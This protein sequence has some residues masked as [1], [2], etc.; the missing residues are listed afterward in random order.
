MRSTSARSGA[1]FRWW[2]GIGTVMGRSSTEPRSRLAE[3]DDVAD[4]DDFY[5]SHLHEMVRL[6][7]LI[8]RSNMAAEDLAHDAFLK[9]RPRF[10]ELNNPAA[11]LRKTVVNECRMWFRRRDVER[12]HAPTPVD[13]L[14]LPP[15]LE[16]LWVALQDVSP[17]RR[18]V[19]FLRFYE[20]RSI[21][22]IAELLDIRPGSVRSLLRRGLASLREALPDDI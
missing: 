11:Y 8:T 10:E 4:F 13:Q 16:E 2:L 7:H 9:V 14:A 17:K 20:D 22:D 5:R 19:L 21:D 1:P 18:I 3:R 12:R 6:A 15:D